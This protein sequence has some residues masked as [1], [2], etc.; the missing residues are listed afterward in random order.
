M[1]KIWL[2]LMLVLLV[3]CSSQDT[4]DTNVE[5]S[6]A[7]LDYGVML[8]GK[9][10]SLNEKFNPKDFSEPLEFFESESCGFEGLDRIYTYK[11]YEVYTYPQGNE[12]YILEISFLGDTK[13]D[14][15][16]GVGSTKAEVLEAYGEDYTE[17][18]KSLVYTND[19]NTINILINGDNVVQ[20]IGFVYIP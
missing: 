8:E 19:K 5:R 15:N 13:T 7:T 6:I 11:D 18:G 17:S 2:S 4:G 12:E 1:K 14:R 16:I 10:I 9:E 3:G 20:S